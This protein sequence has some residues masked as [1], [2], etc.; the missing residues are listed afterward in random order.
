[1]QESNMKEG[2]VT[3]MWVKEATVVW[4]SDDLRSWGHSHVFLSGEIKAASNNRLTH[5][6][7]LFNVL[8]TLLL[9]CSLVINFNVWKGEK[10]FTA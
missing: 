4:W 2:E 3:V 5:I 9:V 10:R 8:E 6:H 7:L 1:M